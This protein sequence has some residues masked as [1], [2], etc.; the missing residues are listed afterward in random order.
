MVKSTK[1]PKPISP[2]TKEKIIDY[3]QEELPVILEEANIDS[4]RKLV[5]MSDELIEYIMD[6]I[7]EDYENLNQDELKKIVVDVIDKWEFY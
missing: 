3:V 2:K 6:I 4:S 5:N 1:Q 7:N